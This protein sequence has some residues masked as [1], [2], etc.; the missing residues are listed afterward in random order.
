MTSKLLIKNSRMLACPTCH[1]ELDLG[2]GQ[3][4]CSVCGDVFT[5]SEDG[6]PLL[7]RAKDWAGARADVTHSIKSFYEENPFPNYDDLDSSAA[8]RQKA[9]RGVFARLLDEQIPFGAKILEVGC[10]TGQLS[11]FLRMSWLR[12][13]IGADLCLNSLKL[14]QRFREENQIENVA[15]LHMH[16]FKPA[17][18]PESFDVLVSN[19]VLHHTGDPFLGFQTISRLLK[20]VGICVI[21]LYKNYSPLTPYCLRFLFS[22]SRALLH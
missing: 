8:L 15:F 17:F 12:T 18:K 4:R 19:G 10:G 3:I 21:R 9:E 20:I 13:V 14:A 5:S 6:I 7:F 1:G 11:N 22:F 16:L 2:S